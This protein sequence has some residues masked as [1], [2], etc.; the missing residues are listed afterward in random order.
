MFKLYIKGSILFYNVFNTIWGANSLSLSTV[1]ICMKDLI[2]LT[3][4]PAVAVIT[5]VT[6]SQEGKSP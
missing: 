5:M 2:I 4:E 6:F 1:N 3:K